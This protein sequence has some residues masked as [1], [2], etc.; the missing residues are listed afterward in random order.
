FVFPSLRIVLLDNKPVHEPPWVE[1]REDSSDNAVTMRILPSG[2]VQSA[3]I[4]GSN[5]QIIECRD[6]VRFRPKPNAARHKTAVTMINK[7]LLVQPA[8]DVITFGGDAQFVPL[9]KCRSFHMHACHLLAAAV[10]IV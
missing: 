5:N 3:A 9:A 1:V 10:V 7:K 2:S 8:L 6:R 4:N